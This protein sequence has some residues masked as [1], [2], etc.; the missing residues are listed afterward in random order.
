VGFDLQILHQSLVAGEEASLPA[1]A[2]FC[3]KRR[4]MG[5]TSRGCCL[6]QD[7]RQGCGGR[8]GTP[9]TPSARLRIGSILECE[10]LEFGGFS[11]DP[12]CGW[13]W[14]HRESRGARTAA[15]RV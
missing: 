7:D 3:H 11:G 1:A 8:A 9:G 13:G 10:H 12:G 14:L 2:S 4:V 15:G 5:I 6:R